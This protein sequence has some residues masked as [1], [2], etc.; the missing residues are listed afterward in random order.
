MKEDLEED[1]GKIGRRSVRWTVGPAY[2]PFLTTTG[3]IPLSSLEE[4]LQRA[5]HQKEKWIIYVC[6]MHH[7][8]QRKVRQL[9]RS[10]KMGKRIIVCRANG[11]TCLTIYDRNVL[12]LEALL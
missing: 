9:L 1:L 4:V 12:A 5:K 8:N 6:G 3:P 10:L 2:E 7:K 11:R